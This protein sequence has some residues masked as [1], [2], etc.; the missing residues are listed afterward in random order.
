MKIKMFEARQ[1]SYD[2]CLPESDLTDEF[3]GLLFFFKPNKTNTLTCKKFFSVLLS[4]LRSCCCLRAFWWLQ[5]MLKTRTE[6]R[7]VP[8]SGLPVQL[9]ISKGTTCSLHQKWA[10]FL[11]S[12]LTW[13][14]ELLEKDPCAHNLKIVIFCICLFSLLPWIMLATSCSHLQI[15]YKQIIYLIYILLPVEHLCK[16]AISLS[17][18]IILRR[19]VQNCDF[20]SLP[21]PYSNKFVIS[22]VSYSFT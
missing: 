3:C 13:T 19:F 2:L 9:A 14:M 21:F 5:V 7:V 16:C 10:N 20:P 4:I 12:K 17:S 8:H 6:S 1:N 18:V 11:F 22:F 15:F